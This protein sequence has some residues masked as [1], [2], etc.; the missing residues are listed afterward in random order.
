MKTN[1]VL[2]LTATALLLL[3][4]FSARSQTD[5]LIK[6]TPTIYEI[7]G[8]GGNVVVKET[9]RGVILIDAGTSYE[10]GLRIKEIVTGIT[11][12]PISHIILTHYHY[13]HTRGLAAFPKDVTIM[14]HKNIS[15]ALKKDE[16]ELK[17]E[18]EVTIPQKI[19]EI[20]EKLASSKI[21]KTQ[22]AKLDSAL[23]AETANLKSQ[24]NIRI[25]YPT[26]FYEKESVII[27][28][29]DTILLYHPGNAHT[30]G[31]TWVLFKNEKIAALGDMLFTNTM[32]YIDEQ[33]G[34]NTLNW[35]NTLD[36]LASR[37]YNVY[38]SG[39]ANLAKSADL[40]RFTAYLTDLRAAVKAE[41]EKGKSLGETIKAVD[42][43]AYHDFG[44]QFFREQNIEAIYKELSKK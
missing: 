6:I 42:L 2:K 41:I 23:K 14:G 16:A 18:I 38:I 32:P 11:Q 34:A 40:K 13:D 4:F 7:T 44:F 5:S 43:A 10:A 28:E 35:I 1:F 24:Q 12:K 29:K 33:M 30:N 19:K 39:H 37:N 15:A 27:D 36:E 21:D 20:K 22:K 8:L 17:K 25:V 26:A 9:S 3:A 31:D